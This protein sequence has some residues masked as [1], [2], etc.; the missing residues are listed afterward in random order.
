MMHPWH[1]HG[2][3][4]KVVARDGRPLGSAAFECDTLGVNPGERYDALITVRPP[5]GLGVPLPHPAA[6]RMHQ[7]HVR[8]GQHVDRGPEEGTRGCDPP[9]R[10]G[11]GRRAPCSASASSSGSSRRAVPAPPARPVGGARV[12]SPTPGFA[13]PSG[14]DQPAAAYFT[15]TNPATGP[16]DAA[17]GRKPRGELRPCCIR[18]RPTARGMTG[19]AMVDRSRVPAGGT[20]KLEPGGYH[21]MMTGVTGVAV[22]ASIELDLTFEHAGTIEVIRRRSAPADDAHAVR[23]PRADRHDGPPAS[24]VRSGS[25][26]RFRGPR[27]ARGTGRRQVGT[28]PVGGPGRRLADARKPGMRSLSSADDGALPSP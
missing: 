25:C 27:G 18:P 7:W 23:R 21:V 13:L 15:I 10:H 3:T 6:R 14:P 11:V 5:R 26:W 22:G 12:T 19:M 9:D 24:T 8:D 16:D 1:V 17:G 28:C 20:V 4:M 2:Y